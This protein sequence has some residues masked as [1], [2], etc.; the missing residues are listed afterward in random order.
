VSV[1]RDGSPELA[2]ID[3]D[4]ECQRILERR[5]AQAF[6]EFDA[7]PFRPLPPIVIDSW[8]RAWCQR[9]RLP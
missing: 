2:P 1:Q 3:F 9:R 5:L 4:A 7:L 8:T 6:E